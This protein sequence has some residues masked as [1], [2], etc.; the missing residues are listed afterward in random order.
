MTS[1]RLETCSKIYFPK[2]SEGFKNYT[3][4]WYEDQKKRHSPCTSY[5]ISK[6]NDGAS[7]QAS[8]GRRD[9]TIIG[10]KEPVT[11]DNTG[12]SS[13]ASAHP[14][15]G[16]SSNR[17]SSGEVRML[18]RSSSK[19]F[20]PLLDFTYTFHLCKNNTRGGHI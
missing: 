15:V 10:D 12:L 11:I 20:M 14:I 7:S 13:S 18:K 3:K 2:L 17:K 4:A 6:L 5:G 19:V 8:T 9:V 16:Q 1:T